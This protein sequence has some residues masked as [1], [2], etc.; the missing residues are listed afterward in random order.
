ME[1][2]RHD[3]GDDDMIRS[4]SHLGAAA[5]ALAFTFA[6]AGCDQSDRNQAQAVAGDAFIAAQ[7]RTKAAAIDPA[8]LNLLHAS[9]ANG[10]VTLSGTVVSNAERAD[11]EKAA[12]SVN[13]V[14]DV[15]DDVK[16]DPS[17]PTGQQIEADL[18]LAAK[19]HAALVEQTGV[20][21]A[22]VHVDVHRGTVTL[23]GV[24][25]SVAHRDVADQ[26]VRGVTGVQKL[27]DK[28]TIASR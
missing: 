22:N 11:I 10:T 16:V 15:V 3:C 7:V 17:A 9:C 8:T 5:A 4:A 27:I 12:R 25:P 24:L 18:G 26:T 23:T 1:K 28:I 14:K 20:N 6:L 19:V 13:G 2:H 21:A